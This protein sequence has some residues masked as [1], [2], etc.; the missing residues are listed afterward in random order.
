MDNQVCLFLIEK[1]G[2]IVHRSELGAGKFSRTL[3]LPVDI[4]TEKITAQRKDG[5]MQVVLAK[6]EHAKPKKIDIKLS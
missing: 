6:A 3:E 5:I 2:Q 4:D 1:E